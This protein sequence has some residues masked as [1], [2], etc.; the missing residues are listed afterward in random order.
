MDI[1]K[2]HYQ[3]FIALGVDPKYFNLSLLV[4]ALQFQMT[5]I[6]IK[7]TGCKGIC[8]QLNVHDFML[9]GQMFYAM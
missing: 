3:E 7:S 1:G 9:K 8:Q 5:L 4:V 2:A 6:T